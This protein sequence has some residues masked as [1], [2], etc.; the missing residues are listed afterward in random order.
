M[1]TRFLLVGTVVGAITL[2]A[3]QTLS[4]VAIPWHEATLHEFTNNDAVVQTLRSNA[5]V[6]GVYF[7]PQGVLAATS[8][9]PDLA[10]KTQLMNRPLGFQ[11]VINLAAAFLLCLV[12]LRLPAAGAVATATTLA[13]AGL[14]AGVIIH[15]SDWNWYGFSFPYEAVNAI[16]HTIQFFLAG[17]VIAAIR[18]KTQPA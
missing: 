9:T 13:I 5:P 1:S 14:A 16:D 2:Y 8:F 4:N 6:N 11:V 15:F 17:L 7:S 18:R 10:D 12:V 3:W